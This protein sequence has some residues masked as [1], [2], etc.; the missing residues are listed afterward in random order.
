MSKRPLIAVVVIFMAW[1]VLDFVIHGLLLQETYAATASLW[2]PMEEM[3][4]TLMYIV[5]L[6]YTVCFVAIYDVLVS[7]KSIAT[8]IKYGT[9]FGLAAGISM[10]FGSYTF[11]PITW[12]LALSW[13]TGTLVEAIVAGALVGAIIKQTDTPE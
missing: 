7:E 2:R 10:G 3:N 4:M 5:T 9:L 12:S 8:G 6:A 13:F 1:S 11:M